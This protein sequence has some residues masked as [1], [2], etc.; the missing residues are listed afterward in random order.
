[1]KTFG[2]IIIITL[3]FGFI[4]FKS[5]IPITNKP[6][7]LNTKIESKKNIHTDNLVLNSNQ[8]IPNIELPKP[9]ESEEIIKHFAYALSYNELFEQ[10]NWVAYELT[11]IETI[12]HFERT[13]KFIVDDLVKTGSATNDDYKKS[14]YD[15][16]HLAPAG[17]M[18]WSEQ[19]MKESF[20]YSNISPQNPSFNRGIW[21]KTEELTREWAVENKSLY[22]VT[23]PILKKKLP[24]IG[25]NKVSIP[26]YYFKAILDYSEPEI[27][28]IAFLIPN[29][30]S[31]ELLQ[32]FT[33]NID[34][35]EHLTGYDFYYQLP[36]SIENRLEK[37]NIISNW[38][39]KE[40]GIKKENN[41]TEEQLKVSV[42]CLGTTKKGN[43]CLNKTLNSSGYCRDHFNQKP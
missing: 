11:D 27:K 36:D 42:Q 37:N 15:R 12:S 1:M 5:K 20:Y 35:L 39:W 40:I 26:N 23:G 16:G 30:A 32:N 31:K 41:E 17:D 8:K 6:I 28:A 21:K 22:I 34:S 24:T 3:T 43:R 14:G 25:P 10:A 19:A 29:K 38:N 4:S 13:N 33:V 9:K 2:L 18:G 7:S